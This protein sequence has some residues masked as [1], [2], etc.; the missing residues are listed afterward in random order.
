[1][2]ARWGL[3]VFADFIHSDAQNVVAV[4]DGVHFI[5]AVLCSV[6]HSALSLLAR[7][8]SSCILSD[9]KQARL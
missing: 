5:V 7:T 9:S 1:M 4:R 6:L 2:A 3:L 8:S